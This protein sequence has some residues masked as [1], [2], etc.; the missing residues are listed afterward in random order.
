MER[1]LSFDDIIRYNLGYCL[2]GTY[3]NRIIIPSY[4]SD[5][6]L[7]L[8]D[9]VLTPDSSRFWSQ[10]KSLQA[11]NGGGAT[12]GLLYDRILECLLEPNPAF[13]T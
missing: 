11:S 3:Q 6:Q 12:F 5:G 10:S 13:V 4:D 2:S 1:G 8:V 7:M 9:E